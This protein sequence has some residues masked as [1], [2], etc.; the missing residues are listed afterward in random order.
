MNFSMIV[1]HLLLIAFLLPIS[2]SLKLAS[3][4]D[5]NATEPSDRPGDLKVSFNFSVV[6]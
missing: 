6:L 2:S 4:N 5:Q 1:C 3:T